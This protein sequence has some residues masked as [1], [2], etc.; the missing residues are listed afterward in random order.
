MW[1]ALLRR[2]DAASQRP[3]LCD[4]AR[5][6]TR[7]ELCDRVDAFATQLRHAGV[8]PGDRVVILTG[9]DVE[10]VV[11][12][13]AAMRCGAAYVPIDRSAPQPRRRDIADEIAARACIA[14]AAQLDEMRAAGRLAFAT[15]SVLHAPN[16]NAAFPALHA[17]MLAYVI[18]TS[19]STGRPKGV[20]V[21][22]GNLAALF[23]AHRTIVRVDE[24][25]VCLNTTPFYFDGSIGD[26]LFP[27]SVGA[28]VQLGPALPV[29]TTL[30]RLMQD[31][32]A[33]HLCIVPSSLA[34]MTDEGARQRRYDLSALQTI[35]FG[36]EAAEPSMLRAWR[37]AWPQV[38]LVNGYGPTEATYVCIARQWEPGTP[39]GGDT[40]PIGTPY[41]GLRA[42]LLGPNLDIVHDASNT[43]G[44]NGRSAWTEGELALSGA[45]VSPGYWQRAEEDARAFVTI[46]GTRFYR[47]GD[48]CGINDE[49]ELVYR[50]RLDAQAKINGYRIHMAEVR[51]ALCREA[52]VSE[53]VAFPVTPAIGPAALGCALVC[54]AAF[55][56]DDVLALARSARERLPAYMVPKYFLVMPGGLPLLPSGKVDVR[57]ASRMLHE[58]ASASHDVVCFAATASALSK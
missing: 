27:L 26:C 14:P 46:E 9:K 32:R 35:V 50:G 54:P 20:M 47:T 25:S 37:A 55:T 53:C 16:A 8:A 58:H 17:G 11:S 56:R 31:R 7:A 18:Y 19:G 24:T 43:P 34:R 36:G 33:T 39:L 3:A 57:A 12:L 29:P 22:H 4:A 23:A 48:V 41:A 30:L 2:D 51:A 45:Q 21:T 44:R 42:V 13:Y 5:A 52:T 6:L 10:T 28:T 1:H 49:H 15:E 38:R 40:L